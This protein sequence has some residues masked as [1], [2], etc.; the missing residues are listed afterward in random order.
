M[1]SSWQSRENRERIRQTARYG[2]DVTTSESCTADFANSHSGSHR[3][4]VRNNRA[5]SSSSECRVAA[6][7]SDNGSHP[8]PST[9][10]R[11][12]VSYCAQSVRRESREI[13]QNCGG[14]PSLSD[15]G[16]TRYT[17][18]DGYRERRTE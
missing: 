15:D 2:G 10:G 13:G 11:Q 16:R 17:D 3:E 5:R 9:L 14:A 6:V 7:V 1:R 4:R 12:G 18:R 8:S